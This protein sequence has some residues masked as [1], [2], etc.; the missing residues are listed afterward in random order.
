MGAGEYYAHS[1]EGSPAS[2]WH[3]LQDHLRCVADMAA[4]FAEAFASADSGRLAGLWHDL[5]KYRPEFQK[6]LAGD[7]QR[8][9]HAIVGALLARSEFRDPG[10]S[11]PLAF[12]IAG[13]H[14]CLADL[15]ALKERLQRNAPLL[16]D[17]LPDVPESLRHL[18][19][20][21]LADRLSPGRRRGRED[22]ERLRRSVEF[23][24]RFLYSALVDA[25]FLDTENFYKPDKRGL[26]AKDFDTVEELYR[27]TADYMARLSAEAIDKNPSPVNFARREVLEA[28]RAAADQEPG[29]FSL[30][31]PTGA[32]KTFSGMLFALRHARRHGLRRVIVVIPYTSI[33]E[34]N[35]DKYRRVLG[36]AN[37]VE[38]HSALDPDKETERNRLASENWDAP[39]IVTTSVQFFESLF[40]NRPSR[41]RKLHNVAGSVVFL[42]EVQSLP[43]RFLLSILDALNELV[44]NFGCSVVLSTATQP[45]LAERTAF[46]CGL[47][48]VREIVPGPTELARR[49][50]RVQATWPGA[51]D[52]PVEWPAL[53]AELS[54]FEQVLAIVHRRKDARELARLLPEGA[55]FHLSALMCPS[56]RSK[57]L[58]EVCAALE[59][60][61]PCRLVST[62]LVEAGVD[63]DFPVVY[64]ALGGLDSIIQ[65][66][67][68][69]NREG[70]LDAGRLVVFRAP[71]EPPPGTPRKALESTESLLRQHA[72][73]LS[74]DDPEVSEA[75]FRSLY[76]KEDLDAGGIQALRQ[77]FKFE[78]TAHRFRLIEDGY[79]TPVVVPYGEVEEPL[80]TL[81]KDGPSRE[82]LRRLQPFMV[83]L[84]EQDVARLLACGALEVVQELVHVLTPP[85]YHLYTEAFGLV[86]DESPQPDPEAS[87]G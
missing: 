87:I 74:L 45:A 11:L 15:E 69:C 8:V 66:A 6:R 61:R 17:V 21:E 80:A 22:R 64:R 27:Q 46:P 72:G 16:A 34:Q 65:A 43:S 84:Y 32:G 59:A 10:L 53:A 41:C 39:I 38:H 52:P 1:R 30:S 82:V 26:R 14:G 77:E 20:P 13:H 55:R 78:E 28:C 12:V 47:K 48:G 3:K 76:F 58:A 62:Q 2:E 9:D 63:I 36:Q 67:G 31:A 60:K 4:T 37:V 79:S 19:P 81:R 35:A 49:L 50:S 73:A 23:W 29:F 24:I 5:G 70:R 7:P 71:T 75:F 44:Q 57:V 56:H 25:D 83:S 18:P 51:S 40:A 54:R 68:R 42:D 86:V 85:F 33:I